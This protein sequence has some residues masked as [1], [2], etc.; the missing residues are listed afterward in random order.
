[1]AASARKRSRVGR[2]SRKPRT[3]GSHALNIVRKFFG[4]NITEVEDSDK[5]INVEVTARDV[6]ASERKAHAGCA[7]AVA[8]KRSKGLDG[9]LISTSTAYLVKGHKAVRY[10]VPPSVAR[11]IVSF[12]RGSGFEPGEYRLDIV[13]PTSRFGETRSTGKSNGGHRKPQ[14]RHLISHNVRSVLGSDKV[15]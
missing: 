13:P 15:R 1:M 8:C 12:D 14:A 11:E 2:V 3:P 6:N 9:V 10:R 5:P 7:L 4:A